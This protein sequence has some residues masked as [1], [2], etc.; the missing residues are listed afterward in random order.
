MTAIGQSTCAVLV[1]VAEDDHFRATVEAVSAQT[2]VPTHLVVIDA[3]DRGVIN[4]ESLPEHSHLY[5]ARSAANLGRAIDEAFL[6]QA[7]APLLTQVR[8]LWILHADSTPEADCLE[9]L[10][11]MADTG[12]TI[13][14]IGPKLLDATGTRALAV[15]I[16]ATRGA[17]RQETSLPDEIDQGQHDGRVDVLAVSTAGMLVSSELWRLSGGFDPILGP[18][19]DG[20]EFGRRARRLGYRVVVCPKARVRHHRRSWQDK[21]SMTQV[22]RARTYNWLLAV[23]AWQ[24][25]IAMFLAWVSAPIR[26]LVF[27]VA[28]QGN[29]AWSELLAGLFAL[30]DSPHL[31]AR[32]AWIHRHARAP[33]RAVAGLE[34][35]SKALR[36]R[37]L[38]LRKGVERLQGSEV[39][40]ELAGAVRLHRAR[41]LVGVGVV[42]FLLT[43]VALLM[44][45]PVLDGVAGAAWAQLPSS[46]QLLWD[47]AW[48]PWIPGADG[49]PGVSDPLVVILAFMSAPAAL[50]GVSPYEF[51]PWLLALAMPAAGL[52]AWALASTLTLRVGA[53][54]A[55]ALLWSCLPMMTMSLSSGHLSAV[56]FHVCVPLTCAVW[57]KALGIRFTRELAGEL[58]AVIIPARG[59]MRWWGPAALTLFVATGL[60]PGFFMLAL[61]C[62]AGVFLARI[63][64]RRRRQR[65]GRRASSILPVALAFLP[66][67]LLVVP[68]TVDAVRRG[69]IGAFLAVMGPAHPA[70]SS[71]TVAPWQLILGMPQGWEHAPHNSSEGMLWALLSAPALFLLVWALIRASRSAYRWGQIDASSH[72]HGE[73]WRLWI[74][75]VAIAAAGLFMCAAYGMTFIPV[76]VSEQGIVAHAWP[77]PALSCAA[78]CLLVAILSS[79]GK[80][81]GERRLY[82]L[83]SVASI[84]A[85]A[86]SLAFMQG[87]VS[88]PVGERIYDSAEEA[89]PAAS[90]HAQDS[91]RSA[92]VLHVD[93]SVTPLQVRLYRGRGPVITDS[94]AYLRYAEVIEHGDR[95]SDPAWRSLATSALTALTAPD[96]Q[97]IDSLAEH[98]IDAIVVASIDSE[99]AA[100]VVRALDRAPGVE[101]GAQTSAG[102]SWRIRPRGVVPARAMFIGHEQG[103]TQKEAGALGAGQVQSL[104]SHG[105]T[106]TGYVHEGGRV[107]L[108]ERASEHWVLRAN[109]EVI[110][111]ATHQWAQS[112]TIPGEASLVLTYD[113][114][115]MSV[116]KWLIIASIFLAALG[117]IPVGRKQ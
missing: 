51:A 69:G 75:P 107:H 67:F 108:A 81:V 112:W 61:A 13:G 101:R 94:S 7:L 27:A 24:L 109:G 90:V 23:P 4:E 29:R 22:L 3:S 12:T 47:A 14:V 48:T 30:T 36:E 37:R 43:V 88:L 114:P 105:L 53:R 39:S 58:H 32:R 54:A 25:P 92:R 19:G 46:W 74:P 83:V 89:L 87:I 65:L 96:P 85:L 33:R 49:A 31:F 116:W 9:H 117:S 17:R 86:T 35:P 56:L 95:D 111:P 91:A 10:L 50:F 64:G 28:G 63:F 98:G 79:T 104:D 45:M 8:F 76:G 11:A 71:P 38:E 42:A 6:S 72:E 34:L 77:A 55:A 99:N 52:S 80:T 21:Q 106:V 41:S 68:S 82:Q 70:Q 15:G 16:T 100:P 78:L 26:A 115:W 59:R 40:P 62:A 57:L 44:S 66:S 84:G 113:A 60:T 110:A 1:T 93:P 18:Y 97:A 2:H 20:L 73:A 5:H 102:V 103:T